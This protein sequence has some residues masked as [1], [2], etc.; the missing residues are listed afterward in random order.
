MDK[1][2]EDQRMVCIKLSRTQ[3]IALREVLWTAWHEFEIDGDWAYNLLT[4]IRGGWKALDEGLEEPCIMIQIV[5]D[6]AITVH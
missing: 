5:E 3:A 1:K 6:R 4:S 2:L